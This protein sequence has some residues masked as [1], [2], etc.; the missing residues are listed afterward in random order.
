MNP[1]INQVFTTTVDL[2]VGPDE[3]FALVTEPERLR[4]WTSV[5]ATVDLRAGGAWRWQVTPSHAAGGTIREVDPGRRV[6]LGWGWLGDD[7][8]PPD[9][10]TVTVTIEPT[11]SGSRVTLTH[12]GLPTQEQVDGHAEGWNHYLERLELLAVKGEAGRDEWAWAPED[13]DPIVAGYAVLASIQPML[14]ALTAEDR[15]KRTPCPDMSCHQLAVHLMESMIGL[16]AM[17]GVELTIPGE[18][19]LETKV[20]WLADAALSAWRERGLEGTVTDPAGHDLPATFGPAI[21]DV[22]LLLHGWDLAQGSGLTIE[23]SD[24]VVAFVAELAG[25]VIEGGRGSNFADE[26]SPA[27][28]ASALERFAAYSGRRA[29]SPA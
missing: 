17:A 29:L 1:D 6:V 3:A 11:E 7:V 27:N 10:S 21:I 18:G 28:G 4:R 8:L 12:A 26:I 2:P 16:G 20:S 24:E 9:A 25:Q 23:V 19:S 15:P 5:C 13:L 14:R 22:E